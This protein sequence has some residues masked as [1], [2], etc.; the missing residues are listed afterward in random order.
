MPEV[1]KAPEQVTLPGWE[2]SPAETTLLAEVDQELDTQAAVDTEFEGGAP[3]PPEPVAKPVPPPETVAPAPVNPELQR[4]A[5]ERTAFEE[6]QVVQTVHQRIGVYKQ[7]LV[8]AGVREDVAGQV[9]AQYGEGLGARFQANQAIRQA[10]EIAKQAKA[11]ELEKSTGAAFDIL[12][13]Y[14]DP[15]SMEAAAKAF[16]GQA[17]RFAAL[18]KQVGTITKAPPQKFDSG[19]G[20]PA[21]TGSRVERRRAF[22]SGVAPNTADEFERTFGYRP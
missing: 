12:M 7:Q 9:A 2:F 10:N 18:E 16:G 17:A 21:T 3:T 11:R 19:R 20:S 15:G 5:Q 14:S 4:L 6:Q 8:A 22:A 13:Q 1:T